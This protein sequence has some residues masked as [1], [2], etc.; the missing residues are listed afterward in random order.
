MK[1]LL[2]THFGN[3]AHLSPRIAEAIQAENV[4]R[5]KYEQAQIERLEAGPKLVGECLQ[6]LLAEM[7]YETIEKTMCS[8]LED[9]CPLPLYCDSAFT[10][11]A[12][13]RDMF[14]R[15][16]GALEYELAVRGTDHL[17]SCLDR[18]KD[19]LV[20]DG[21]EMPFY[22]KLAMGLFGRELMDPKF[23][24]AY[25]A[26]QELEIRS[27]PEGRPPLDVTA[28]LLVDVLVNHHTRMRQE[29]KDKRKEYNM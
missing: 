5:T 10:G 21:T 23:A 12:S 27:T 7:S 24:P 14:Y 26:L 13:G 17:N 6:N 28:I 15:L 9:D 20:F 18:A 22:L 29:I 1:G 2:D 8:R 11:D 16:A 3:F 4:A 19:P 25:S